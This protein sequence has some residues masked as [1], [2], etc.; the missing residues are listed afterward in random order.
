MKKTLLVMSLLML[1][2]SAQ[3][4]FSHGNHSHPEPE[5]SVPDKIATL[6]KTSETAGHSHD[7]YD[8]ATTLI[9]QE[10]KAQPRNGLLWYQWARVLQHDHQFELALEATDEA[11]KLNAEFPSAWLLKSALH[12]TLAQYDQAQRACASLLGKTMAL[13]VATCRLEVESYT[14]G[15][16][17]AYQKLEIALQK[18][19]M[20][21]GVTGHWMSQVAAE[22]AYRKGAYEEAAK[23]LSGVEL[24]TVPVSYLV[25]WSDVQLALGNYATLLSRLSAIVAEYEHIADALILRLALAEREVQDGPWRQKLDAVMQHRLASHDTH[26][27]GEVARYLLHFNH[28]PERALHWAKINWQQSKLPQDKALLD[29]AQQQ[30]L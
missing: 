3:P 2:L 21:D 25:L 22:M 27:A 28:Q 9:R 30:K 17:L 5:T 7:S 12:L 6:L 16:D 15:T 23:W 4:T 26:H 18:F 8:Q 1:G 14:N 29:Q 13:I 11:I 19:P 20:P 24:N 10:L